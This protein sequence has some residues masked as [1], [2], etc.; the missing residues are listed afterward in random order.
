MGFMGPNKFPRNWGVR[1]G[2]PPGR[3]EALEISLAD[4]RKAGEG[5]VRC[6]L[7]LRTAEVSPSPSLGHLEAPISPS[8]SSSAKEGSGAYRSFPLLR[9]LICMGNHLLLV[10]IDLGL[11]C[12][13]S[14]VCDRFAFL[15]TLL[16]QTWS[17]P[18]VF[19]LLLAPIVC[20]W[21]YGSGYLNWVLVSCPCMFL[22]SISFF[23]R[24]IAA[25]NWG[26]IRSF[27]FSTVDILFSFL[28]PKVCDSFYVVSD[29]GMAYWRFSWWS[30]FS[31]CNGVEAPSASIEGGPSFPVSGQAWLHVL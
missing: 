19:S 31:E 5:W 27:H 23:F 15:L 6:S 4:D 9:C 30:W 25:A 12:A 21:A 22:W 28:F 17:F 29:R 24:P 20:V 3:N 8:F 26:F 1:G 2:R 7:R 13:G 11:S 14:G 16:S 10:L 18:G